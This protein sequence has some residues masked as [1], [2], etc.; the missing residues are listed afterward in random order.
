VKLFEEATFKGFVNQE[1]TNTEQN[2]EVLLSFG[3]IAK[4]KWMRLHDLRLKQA[5][6]PI[7]NLQK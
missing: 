2:C 6:R 3:V 4:K 5:A 7:I 1:I